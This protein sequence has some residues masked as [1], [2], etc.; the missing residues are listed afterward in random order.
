MLSGFALFDMRSIVTI[1]IILLIG[2]AVYGQTSVPI[3]LGDTQQVNSLLNQ[4]SLSQKNDSDKGIELVSK[5]LMLADEIKFQSGIARA[6]A[7]LGYL[8]YEKKDYITSVNYLEKARALFLND[9]DEY[10]LAQVLKKMGDVY[11]LRGYFRQSS[12]SYREALP[13]LRKT[14]QEVLQSECVEGMGNIAATFDRYKNAAGFFQR[15]LNLKRS[16][17]DEK[18]IVDITSKIYTAYLDAKIYDSALYFINQC[19]V[20]KE[21][22]NYLKT[23]AYADASIA[24]SLSGQLPAAADALFNADKVL[25]VSNNRDEKIKICIARTVYATAIGDRLQ[26]QKFFD[27]AGVLLT[28]SRNPEQAVKGLNYL[29]EISSQKGDY[30]TAFEML[31]QA[32]KYK[33][34]FRNE[35]MDRI[36]AEVENASEISLKNNEI[37]YLNLLNKLKAEQLSKEE[38]KRMAL[39]RENILQ[40]SSLAKQQ[41]LME[42]LE[43]ES[44]LRKQQFE[45]EK[46]LRLSLSRENKLK[47]QVLENEKRNKG[48]LWLGLA[49]MTLFVGIIFYQFKKQQNKNRII[50][51]QSAELGVLN[52][53]IH[54]RVKNNLQVISSMLDLQSQTLKDEKATSIIKEG[55]QRVQ[56]MAFI[57]QNLYQGNTVNAVNMNEYIK[58]LSGHLFQTYNIRPE[59]IQLHTQIE[60]FNLHT[61]TAIPLGMILNE[62]IS[63]SL[64]YA[65]KGKDDGDIWV[66]LKKNNN[67][68]L[69]QVKDNG[70]GMPPGFDPGHTSSFGYEM[71][72]AFSQKLKARMKIESNGGTDV[73]IIISKFKTAEQL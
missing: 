16:I 11:S 10:H 56:S 2:K 54:H 36:K 8:Y 46:E 59:K 9:N 38:L 23:I 25:P 14:K 63:N 67:E 27:S 31:K 18:G 68:L 48:I 58:I 12:D 1:L 53:E 57:H 7:L 45:K 19:F 13:L 32:E 51:K 24:Y 61:D 26:T 42:A 6:N 44:N 62:L 22:D 40:D 60:N 20:L 50:K 17:G 3:S 72:N 34:L 71:I 64:K 55:I 21:A 52:K 47:Q 70:V 49:A 35:N 28:G 65:F 5:A 39:L 33:D 37:E 73:Q 4:G 69:L 41:L 15:S 29:A 30:K 66:C 43:T